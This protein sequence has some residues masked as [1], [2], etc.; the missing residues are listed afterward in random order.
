M[1]YSAERD[2]I[3]AGLALKNRAINEALLEVTDNISIFSPIS[4][5]ML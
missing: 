3:Q 2:K 5:V 4:R 1:F